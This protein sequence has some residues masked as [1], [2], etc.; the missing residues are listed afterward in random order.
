MNSSEEAKQVATQCLKHLGITDYFIESAKVTLADTTF[1]EVVFEKSVNV[2]PPTY[3]L[4]VF[5]SDG[6]TVLIP[7][8]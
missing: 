8:K 7:E 6:C 3:I 2:M 4:T 5:V 1:Y